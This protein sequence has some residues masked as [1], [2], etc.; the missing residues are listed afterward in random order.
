[1]SLAAIQIAL[2]DQRGRTLCKFWKQT[3][4]DRQGRPT[5][6]E[7]WTLTAKPMS[8]K[9]LDHERPVPAANIAPIRLRRHSDGADYLEVP[10]LIARWSKVQPALDGIA[11]RL[12]LLDAAGAVVRDDM[13]A[14]TITVDVLQ[15]HIG[16]KC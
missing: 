1:M 7:P 14:A 4:F 6:I 12:G 9:E 10:G 16:S 5:E 15:H 2:H 8:G 13:A 3:R 11:R